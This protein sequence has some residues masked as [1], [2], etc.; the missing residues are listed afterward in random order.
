MRRSRRR[1]AIAAGVSVGLIASAMFAAPAG[2]DPGVESMS[3]DEAVA[4]KAH[5]DVTA[6]VDEAG[7]AEF[8]VNLDSAADLDASGLTDKVAKTTEVYESL[9]AHADATQ[10]GLRDL[11]DEAGAQYQ[12]FWIVNTIKVSGDSEL[13][14]DLAV[15]VEVDSITPDDAIEFEEPVDEASADAVPDGVEW[16]LENINA[17]QT[18]NDFGAF[19]DDVLIANI[20]TGVDFDHPALADKYR[21]D[22]GDG[23]FTHDYNYYDPDDLCGTGEETCVTHSHGTHTMGTMLGD[24]GGDNQIGVAPNATWITAVGCAP[25]PVGCTEAALLGSGQFILAPTT[26]DGENP[27]PSLAP[28]IVNN[29][30]GSTVDD[31]WYEDMVSAWNEAGIFSSWSAGNNGEA[32]CSSVGAPGIYSHSYSSGA[33]DV[34]DEI[35]YFSSRG[36][37][38]D[39]EIQPNLAAPGVNVRSAIDGGGYGSLSGTSMAAPHTAGVVAQMWSTAPALRGDVAATWTILNQT[40]RDAA[41]SECGGTAENNNV[42]GEGRLDSYAAVAAS[43]RDGV[44]ALSGAVTSGGDARRGAAVDVEGGLSRSTVSGADGDYVF[45]A[46]TAGDYEVTVAKFGY[47]SETTTVTV[48]EGETVVADFDL[49]AAPSGSVSGVVSDGSG[50]GWPLYAEI[51]VDGV[52]MSTFTDPVTG[53]YAFDLP[54]GEYTLNVDAVYPGYDSTSAD[55]ETG[56]ETNIELSADA[57]S[58]SAPGYGYDYADVPLRQTFDDSAL[59][60]GWEIVNDGD[61]TLE[62]FDNPKNRENLTGGEGGFAVADSDAAGSGGVHMVTDLITPPVNMTKAADPVL[63]F[64]SDYRH[65]GGSRASVLVTTDG[66]EIWTELWSAAANRRGT[67]E[68]IDL[69]SYA[70]ATKVQFKF[71]FDDGTSWA[72]WWQLDNVRVGTPDCVA[73]GDSGLVVG[74]VVDGNSGGALNGATVTDTATGASAET[75]ATPDDDN[76]ADGFYWLH[77]TQTGEHDISASRNGWTD[78]VSAVD[79]VASDTVRADFTLG[80]GKLEADPDS[81]SAYVSMG[82]SWTESVELTNTGTAPVTVETGETGGGFEPMGGSAQDTLLPEP[83]SPDRVDVADG[84]SNFFTMS[85]ADTEWTTLS[86]YPEPAFDVAGAYDDGVAYFLGGVGEEGAIASAYAYDVDEAQ[87]SSIADLPEALMQARAAVV[88]GK[89]YVFGGWN[90]GSTSAATYVYDIAAESWS[91]AAPAPSGRAAAG[92]GVVDGQ[93]YIVGGCQQSAVCDQGAN[94]WRYDPS[95]DAWETLAEYPSNVA[96]GACGGVDGQLICA[97]GVADSGLTATYAYNAAADSWEQRADMPRDVWGMASAAANGMLIV[98]NGVVE[99]NSALTSQTLG[100]DP[101]ADEWVNL[102][103]SG[104]QLYR[105][106]MACGVVKAAGRDIG[107]NP[108][109][110]AEMLAGYDDC[111]GAAADVP[112]LSTDLETVVL[113]PGESA[114]MEVAVSAETG[115]GVDQ[116][117]VYDA[118]VVL[119]NDSPYGST[120]VDVTMTV[121]P[122][123]N[124]GKASITVY[125]APQCSASTLPLVGAQVQLM[126]NHGK[127]YDLTTDGAGLAEYWAP[128]GSYTLI[129]SKDGWAAQVKFVELK[130]GRLNSWS[131]TLDKLGCAGGYVND[132]T[133][134]P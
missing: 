63:S 19:G 32:G 56:A 60:E 13:L 92:H 100:Y 43:P 103:D 113:E 107:N 64:D 128:A 26:Q 47:V 74:N 1:Q 76:V 14:A 97:G 33:Y 15:R 80:A 44:G 23:T 133:Q 115:S 111:G 67:A 70:G 130:R 129:V 20:D 84:G 10:A 106:S 116:P 39:G 29:S 134:V 7:E 104:S 102:P 126:S 53:Q 38:R 95:S 79:V 49:D 91:E 62:W 93:I 73:D 87:W 46:L 24:D 85:Q 36:P 5:P 121:S 132:G 117:G 50:Q 82:G 58:C 112:W 55:V 114:T 3:P 22:N 6:A 27:D 71:R 42:F 9:V 16:G 41:D 124:S 57:G 34:D 18:W 4:A 12:T 101:A 123:P 66:G 28:D 37:G 25:S 65:T 122:D 51:D 109:A 81:V 45:S 21:G 89:L 86:D 72:W 54:D 35:A 98:S 48:V 99:N 83:A 88:D 68:E 105:T 61:D 52:D 40:A 110:D 90:S 17:P 69:S 108:V 8:W 2:A 120:Y 94:T 75:A 30:W 77:T 59:P 119:G 127:R 31:P 96:H 125:G 118:R 11:L 78:S 131:F